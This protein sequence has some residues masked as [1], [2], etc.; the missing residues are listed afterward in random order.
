MPDLV[1][2]WLSPRLPNVIDCSRMTREDRPA[3]PFE[4]LGEGIINALVHRDYDLTGAICHLVVTPDTVT[5]KS[6]GAPLAPVTLEQLQSFTAPMHNRNPELQ[7]AFGGTK[8]VEGRGF[9]M[10][11]AMALR[12]AINWVILREP[13]PRRPSLA[14]LPGVYSFDS[15]IPRI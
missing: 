9:G 7:F 3:L 1:E 8:L 4:L 10:R 11:T 13:R 2:Q 6:P 12:K 5:V 15:R 14:G